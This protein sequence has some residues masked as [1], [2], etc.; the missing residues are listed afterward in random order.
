MEL[1]IRNKTS[2]E[3]T[4][5]IY[6][7]VGGVGILGLAI[8]F[9][10]IKLAF[11]S[12]IIIQQTPGM[13][14]GSVIEKSTMDK[15][16]QRAILSAVTSAIAQI[17]PSNAEYQKQCIQAFLAP[18][19]FTKISKVIDDRVATLASQ[20]EL[21]SYYF[22]LRLYEFD[23]ILD[24][25]FVVGDVHT[26]NAAHDTPEAFTFEYQVHFENYRLVVD[27]ETTYAGDRPHNSEWVKAN[28]PKAK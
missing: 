13:P 25:H 14:N 7:L 4:R 24:R 23:P 22:V 8:L 3:K 16:S 21:G 18:A 20:R 1:S 9:L 2:T 12:E 19:A 26:V 6:G 11:Q 5:I 27:D 15:G 28:G 17:N 10:A